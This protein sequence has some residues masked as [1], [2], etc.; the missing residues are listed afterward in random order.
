MSSSNA[1]DDA[2]L[3]IRRPSEE[4]SFKNDGEDSELNHS[5][6]AWSSQRQRRQNKTFGSR[7]NGSR[8]Q[9]SFSLRVKESDSEGSGF[10]PEP[11][12]SMTLHRRSSSLASSEEEGF[13]ELAPPPRPPRRAGALLAR[14][15]TLPSQMPNGSLPSIPRRRGLSRQQRSHSLAMGSTSSLDTLHHSLSASCLPLDLF[16]MIENQPQNFNTEESLYRDR[17]KPRQRRASTLGSIPSLGSPIYKETIAS[18]DTS[19]SGSFAAESPMPD[20]SLDLFGSPESK[21]SSRKRPVCESPSS[22]DDGSTIMTMSSNTSCRRTKKLSPSKFSNLANPLYSNPSQSLHEMRCMNH[23]TDDEDSEGHIESSFQHDVSFTSHTGDHT[24]L[25]ESEEKK[26]D[27]DRQHGNEILS[28]MPSLDDLKFL[29]HSLNQSKDRPLFGGKN[30]WT[31]VP[32]KEWHVTRRSSFMGWLTNVLHFVAN[33]VGNGLTVLRIPAC[34]GRDLLERLSAS[35]KEFHERPVEIV[36]PSQVLIASSIGDRKQQDRNRASR[37]LF[38]PHHNQCPLDFDLASDLE[39]LTVADKVEPP[40]QQL[41]LNNTSRLSFGSSR[42]S[43]DTAP[44]PSFDPSV[45]EP[46]TLYILGHETPAPRACQMV[47][48]STDQSMGTGNRNSSISVP[49]SVAPMQSLEFVETPQ[50]KQDV[51]WGSRPVEGRDW[52]TSDPSDSYLMESMDKRM[53][54]IEKSLLARNSIGSKDGLPCMPM[55]EDV[56]VMKGRASHLSI[57][58][59]VEEQ[60]SM[61][62]EDEVDRVQRRKRASLAKHHR[63]SLCA[64]A[65]ME[66]PRI[67]FP[68]KSIFPT[69]VESVPMKETPLLSSKTHKFPEVRTTDQQIS[70]TSFFKDD[71]LLDTVFS[72]LTEKDL[73][74]STSLVCS[75]WYDAS[76]TAYARLMMASVGYREESDEIEAGEYSSENCDGGISDRNIALTSRGW[77]YLTTRFPWGMFLSEGGF[78]RVYKVY[79]TAVNAEEAISVMDVQA[80]TDKKTI[81]AEL[82]VSVL[83]SSISRRGICPNFVITR[84]V[85]T[86]PHEPPYSHWGSEKNR[87]PKG[88][89]YV[90]SQ[91][92]RKPREPKHPEPGR[93][94]FI[95]MELC[96]RGDAEDFINKQPSKQLDPHVARCALFQIAFALHVG[97]ERFSLKHYDIKL[98]NVFVQAIESANDFVLRYSLGSH[99][100]ALNMPGDQ[101][102]VAKLA[103]YGTA[104]I[105]SESNG[106]PVTVAQFTTLENT[107]P[108]FMT[109]GD[110]ATQGHG[111][112]N[113][114]LGLCMLHL[115][116]GHSP[117]E[118]I[119]EEVRCPPVLKKKLKLIW[120]NKK[121]GDFSVIRSVIRADVYE[122]NNGNIIEGEPDETLYDTLYRYLVLFGIPGKYVDGKNTSPVWKAISASLSAKASN[123]GRRRVQGTDVLRYESDCRKYSMRHGNNELICNARNSLIAMGGG[124]DL[125]LSLCSFNP[126]DR[127]TPLKVIN[128]S[129]M[130]CLRETPGTIYGRDA[131]VQSYD[132]NPSTE[133]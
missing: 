20:V 80:I 125:L 103:D 90:S 71:A 100:F 25:E 50:I 119:V 32:K 8:L 16:G 58:D 14:S 6:T 26:E 31:V 113:W 130:E 33:P 131:T 11:L 7:K 18:L 87:F 94:Q 98:L 34:K 95:R 117:Y 121:A 72:F 42:P 1:D 114:G 70:S 57:E 23:D 41:L 61:I 19:L 3:T 12:D 46:D 63:V 76:A 96:N 78:K 2:L 108:E 85:F 69:I 112:D 120:E 106:Q 128:S 67:I 37:P 56:D 40:S 59:V 82:V 60:D 126:A 47:M 5:S 27:D 132:Y 53:E 99:T 38:P 51:G 129:F 77:E 52:G 88:K 35:L 107:P 89:S 45:C 17:K 116:T 39:K 133:I 115:F 22:G 86:L 79:N 73:M 93:Y 9:R 62:E 81:A 48:S 127:A 118:E 28:T 102:F 101:A 44:R 54:E 124:L 55:S 74:R 29:I 65:S 122:D 30:L 43:F 36:P 75:H 4:M 84:G 91:I 15:S 49:M 68:R 109:Q 13:R 92:G 21:S 110:S 83:L 10:L 66:S 64:A 24:F 105:R 111:H 97:A 123:C 104:N